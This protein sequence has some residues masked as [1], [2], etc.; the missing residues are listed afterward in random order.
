MKNFNLTRRHWIS[1][2]PLAAAAASTTFRNQSEPETRFDQLTADQSPLLGVCHL[3]F[4]SNARKRIIVR[5]AVGSGEDITISSLNGN[6]QAVPFLPGAAYDLGTARIA[7][8]S[9]IVTPGT[10]RAGF[11]GQQSVPFA[12]GANIWQQALAVIATY[13]GQQRCGA[14]T[15][16]AGRPTCHLDD[17]RRRDNGQRVNAAGGW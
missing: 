2:L 8:F 4:L 13:Q 15:N 1:T 10:Y 17:A 14:V 16:R 3:G 5:G 11:R 6:N 9:D 7:D 12:I